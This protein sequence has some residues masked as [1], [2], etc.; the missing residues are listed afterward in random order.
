MLRGAP[1]AALKGEPGCAGRAS[2]SKCLQAGPVYWQRRQPGA[3]S[4]ITSSWHQR[5]RRED[6]GRIDEGEIYLTV[7]RWS[8]RGATVWSSHVLCLAVFKLFLV[9]LNSST[10][11]PLSKVVTSPGLICMSKSKCYINRY[12]YPA[13]KNPQVIDFFDEPSN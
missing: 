6:S 3:L 10:F 4:W 5:Q 7:D 12:I 13:F 9:S 8:Q 1:P 2:V 11:E